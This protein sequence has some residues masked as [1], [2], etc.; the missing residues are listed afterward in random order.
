MLFARLT[1]EL[2]PAD[3]DFLE[4]PAYLSGRTRLQF[5]NDLPQGTLPAAYGVLWCLE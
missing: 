5:E 1:F 2:G 4:S 3:E